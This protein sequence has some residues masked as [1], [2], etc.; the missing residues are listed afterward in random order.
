M[1]KYTRF[2]LPLILFIL[3]SCTDYLCSG[4]QV[5]NRQPNCDNCRILFI[6]SSYLSYAGNDVVDIFSKF[7]GKAGKQV[8]I[9]T[10]IEGG[11]RLNRHIEYHPTIDKINSQ[12]WDYVVLQG[13]SAYVSKEKWHQYL[14]PYLTGFRQIIKDHYDKTSIIYMMP[15]AY[16]DGLT[17][18][19]GETDTYKEMQLNIYNNSIEIAQSIDISIAPAGWAWHKSMEQEYSELLYLNDL[20]HQTFEGAYLTASVLYSTIFLNKAPFIEKYSS[21]IVGDDFLRNIA[22]KIVINDLD[23]WNIY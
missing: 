3:L 21:E 16:L 4:N 20:N 23:D 7:C 14:V 13:N 6:G 5:D 18:I 2:I 17:F 10:S 8:S 9:D 15:W 12:G 1:K 22:Y 11:F 19:E